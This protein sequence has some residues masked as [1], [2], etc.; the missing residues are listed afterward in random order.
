LDASP[1]EIERAARMAAA[2]EFIHKLPNGYETVIGEYGANLSGGQRQRL[3]I[4]R[5]LLLDPPILLLDDATSAVDAETEHEIQQAVE[6][7]M[8][9]RTTILVSNRISTLRRADQILVL[10]RG[11]VSQRG[12]HDE[13]I[14]TPGYY[15]RMAELQLSQDYRGGSSPEGGSP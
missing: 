5:A 8:E 1:F 14:E 10:E 11:R 13:L 15:R 3:A 4:A 7:A 9:Q 2:S 6:Q 12:T